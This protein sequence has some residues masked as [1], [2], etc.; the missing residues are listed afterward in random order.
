[1]SHGPLVAGVAQV[2]VA[3]AGRI[4]LLVDVDFGV[5]ECDRLAHFLIHAPSPFQCAVSSFRC[6][7]A[8][9]TLPFT[10]CTHLRYRS[11]S[12]SFSRVLDIG[13][14]TVRPRF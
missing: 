5:A 8:G 1:M 14:A 9:L 11:Y 10:L 3:L 7:N 4:A 6:C 12:E 2:P 13:L